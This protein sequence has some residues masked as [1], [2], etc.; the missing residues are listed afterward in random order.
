MA[1][2]QRLELLI[3][4]DVCNEKNNM[5]CARDNMSCTRDNMSCARDLM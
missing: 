3:E 2:R 5:S 1:V 4:K